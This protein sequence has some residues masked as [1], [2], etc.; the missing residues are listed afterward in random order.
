VPISVPTPWIPLNQLALEEERVE[1][2]K[3]EGVKVQ[4]LVSP[5][6]VPKALRGYVSDDG[7]SFTIEFCYISPEPTVEKSLEPHVTA[8]IGKN[9]GR[10]YA[11]KLDMRS[12]QAKSVSLRVEVA[13]T[14][15]NVLTHLIEQPVSQMRESNYK[16]AK[17]A[18]E[19]N[20]SRI[21][22]PV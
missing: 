22:Q 1:R 19:Q 8:Q 10:L 5:H 9:S 16:L 14:L 12:L 15:R 6:D 17:E 21:L 2:K 11:I 3:L 20:E 13:E 7:R 18:V 4:V